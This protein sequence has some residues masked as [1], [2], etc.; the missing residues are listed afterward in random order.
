M[1]LKIEAE[2][3]RKILNRRRKDIDLSFI[4]E[5][6][7]YYMR[8]E[9]GMIRSNYPSV[10][11]IIKKFYEEFQS[12][13]ISLRMSKG[14]RTKQ[15]ELLQEWA[16]K[17][18]YATNQGSRVHYILEKE[19][20]EQYGDY[21]KVREPI[22][23]CDDEQIERSNNMI[24]AGHKFLDLMHERNAVLLDTE[25]VLGDPDLGYVGQPDKVWLVENKQ[26]TDYGILITD[27][28]TNKPINFKKQRYTKKMYPPFNNIDSTALG[29][30]YLQLPFYGRLLN[31]ML[32][33]TEF[34]NKKL[35]GSIV[36]LVKED[37]EFEEYKVPMDVI[38]KIYLLDMKKVLK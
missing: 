23:V 18:T 19:L 38:Q 12:D 33:G 5:D 31:K 37:G 7:I 26:G 24:T 28:K 14:D 6:H 15:K 11:K 29:H 22:Y 9:H 27:W 16:D 25:I 10:S 17:G 34:E 3:I 32:E 35:L 36:V 1:D 30:Y 2:K 20:I 13:A 4:E 21:K 8:D